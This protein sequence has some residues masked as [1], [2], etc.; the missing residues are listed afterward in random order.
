M[1]AAGALLT[2]EAVE[3]VSTYWWYPVL[4]ASDDADTQ[5]MASLGHDE[6]RLL[7]APWEFSLAYVNHRYPV[8]WAFLPANAPSLALLMARY[9]VGTVVLP[10]G[11]PLRGALA[12]AGFVLEGEKVHRGVT[13]EIWKSQGETWTA[14]SS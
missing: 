6:R 1:V 4:A 2:F 14:R 9:D 5:F 12:A 13:L 11:H 3:L 8:R 10:V 7:T